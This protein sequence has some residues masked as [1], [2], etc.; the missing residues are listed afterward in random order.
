MRFI[1]NV[2]KEYPMLIK[3]IIMKEPKLIED[4][5]YRPRTYKQY[6]K[7]SARSIQRTRTTIK[8]IILCNDFDYFATFTFDKRKHDRYNPVHCKNVM[9]LWLENQRRNHSPDLQYLIVPELHKDGAIHFHALLKHFNG[10]LKDSGHK[11]STGRPV[12]NLSGYRAGF[13]TCVPV[14]SKEAVSEYIS[15]Y[16]TKDLVS[17]YDK[18]RYWCSNN[19]T[20]PVKTINS[21]VFRRTLPLFKQKYHESEDA[22]FYRIIS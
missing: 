10:R 1:N 6:T 7:P 20:R 9:S 12:Y 13:S 4:Y 22:L 17:L 8:D 19:L 21:S 18:K 16:I 15:K 14:D 11:S 3:V 5:Q 2:T